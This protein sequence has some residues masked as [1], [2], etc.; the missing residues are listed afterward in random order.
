MKIIS[1]IEQK[2]VAV[3]MTSQMS[4]AD[5]HLQDLLGSTRSAKLK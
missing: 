1:A 4:Y 5:I 2:D 3:L